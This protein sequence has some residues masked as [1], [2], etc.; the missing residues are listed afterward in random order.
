MKFE[1]LI[2]MIVHVIM[3]LIVVEWKNETDSFLS[4]YCEWTVDGM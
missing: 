1:I 3:N 2:T 4:K